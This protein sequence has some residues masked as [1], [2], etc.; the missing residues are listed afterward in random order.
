MLLS[1]LL[2]VF[3]LATYDVV[4]GD[5]PEYFIRVNSVS[6][7]DRIINK[8]N[9]RSEMVQLVRNR[10]EESIKIMR[11]FFT[12]L[13]DDKDRWDYIEKYFAGFKQEVAEAEELDQ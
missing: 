2:Q 6:A 4:S 10:H 3:K 12:K 7:I 13:D 9:Y 8:P 1:Q 11:Y 5:V